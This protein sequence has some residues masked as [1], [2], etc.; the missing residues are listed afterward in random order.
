M[1]EKDKDTLTLD[2]LREE[3][4]SPRQMCLTMN[5]DILSIVK[6][7]C[8]KDTIDR[9]TSVSGH[10]AGRDPQEARS[11]SQDLVTERTR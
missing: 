1:N 10:G 4:V 5:M 3:F 6:H 7:I 2:E 11:S 9:V 8:R